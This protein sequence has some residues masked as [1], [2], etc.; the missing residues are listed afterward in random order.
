MD[1]PVGVLEMPLPPEGR[2][3]RAALR[4]PRRGALHIAYSW[5]PRAPD[6][7]CPAWA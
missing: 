4:Q 6:F 5:T 1:S 7:S 2:L 3:P